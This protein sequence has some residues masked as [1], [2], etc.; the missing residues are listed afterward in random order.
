M[1]VNF[2]REFS[3]LTLLCILSGCAS[4]SAAF[5]SATPIPTLDPVKTTNPINNAE[6]QEESMTKIQMTVNGQS[7]PATLN[8]SAAAQALLYQLPV[9]LVMED[10]N[11]N[12]KYIY[13]DEKLAA[14]SIAF[15]SVS[16]GDLMLFGNNCLVLFYKSFATDYSY[17][18]LGSISEVSGLAEAVGT[19]Q[20]E[21]T[22]ERAE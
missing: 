8:N 7:F 4:P 18:S 17:T 21:V 10:L 14:N 15:G 16:A 22:I 9:T 2:Y 12:E 19:G 5:P 3:A 6:E 1:N 11:G 13:L 20:A